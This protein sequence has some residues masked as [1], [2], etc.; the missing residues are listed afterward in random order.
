[1]NF[2]LLIANVRDAVVDWEEPQFFNTFKEIIDG[3]NDGKLKREDYEINY[4]ILGGVWDPSYRDFNM[5]TI[6]K[7]P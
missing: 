7:K 5:R 2:E 6:I 4:H 1:M 3:I